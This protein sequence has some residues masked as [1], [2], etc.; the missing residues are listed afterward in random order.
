M[1]RSFRT[2]VVGLGGIG[3]AALYW[4]AASEPGVVGFER[5][6]LGHG[7]GASQDHSRIIRLAQHEE[8]YASLAP[9]A[10]EAWAHV[11]AASGQRLLT[12]T[13]GLVI[14]DVAARAGL[15]TGSR[16]I[17]GYT[18][19]FDRHGVEYELWSAERAAE[20]FPQF[21]FGGGEQVL[22]QAESGIVDAARANAVHLALARAHGAEVRA[23]TPV[24][25]LVPTAAG[26]EVVTDT[27]TCLVERVILTADAWTNELLPDGEPPFPLL[28]TQE[29]V[30]YY[31]T[32]H[33]KEFSPANFPVFMWHGEHNFYG[34]PVYGE[35][36][37][38]LGQHLGGHPV[39]ADGRTFEADPVRRER[40]REFLAEHVPGFLG[41]E[42]YTKTCLYTIPPDQNFIL[43]SLRT[44]P[45][46]T[47]FVGAGHAY[48][49]ASL[50]GR[51]LAEL[52]ATG[53]TA[54]PVGA[55]G[56]DRAALN[57][58]GFAARYHR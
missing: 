13:G 48:K 43:G 24:R 42:L 7:R 35:V 50:M 17:G 38:K 49:F 33:L 54:H 46:V 5:F 6:D 41:P 36:A 58:P 9:A 23:R 39:T 55:F 40:Q 27:E 44:D 19:M 28:V 26:V 3:S 4:S 29:Q 34:F 45:R 16:N 21:R 12:R 18:A 11:E 22:W 1:N 8:P 56:L 37:T 52:S 32:P 51:V 57:D 15:D 53:T 47:V 20:R 10:Y 31:A 25:K 14:E 2:A 30:T